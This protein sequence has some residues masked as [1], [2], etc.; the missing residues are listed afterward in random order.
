M[1]TAS[2]AAEEE[3][4]PDAQK[5]VLEL[6]VVE[7]CDGAHFYCHAADRSA[8]ALELAAAEESAKK[9]SLKVWEHFS[10]LQEAEA[11]AAATASAAAEEE[12]VPD[13]QKQ[14]LELEVVEICDGA[15]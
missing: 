14:V 6:E 15:S 3:P 2:A 1:G 11:R 13:A 7:I 10:E 8:H 4:V 5:Q 12:P 9:A